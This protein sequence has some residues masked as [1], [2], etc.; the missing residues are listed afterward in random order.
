VLLSHPEALDSDQ[1]SP[2]GCPGS[3][4]IKELSKTPKLFSRSGKEGNLND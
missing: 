1:A 2:P 3:I 4:A